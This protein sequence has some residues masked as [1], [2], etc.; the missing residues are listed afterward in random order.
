MLYR[1][2]R[3]TQFDPVTLE[4]QVAVGGVTLNNLSVE[5]VSESASLKAGDV[6]GL[7]VVGD[8]WAIHQRYVQP[9]TADATEAVTRAGRQTYYEHEFNYESTSS[10]TYTDLT[11]PGP[12]VH[13]VYVGASGIALVYVSANLGIF[14]DFC[15][16]EMGFEVGGST[17]I[18]A[19][20]FPPVLTFAVTPPSAMTATRLIRVRNLNPGMHTFKAKY[21][22]TVASSGLASAR[23]GDRELTVVAV[24]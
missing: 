8:T 15:Q 17:E 2:G 12:I 3:I 23:F 20:A 10:G 9:G 19:D 7:V 16:A 22:V 18:S 4:N 11:T 21:R 5:A 1:Q 6:V 13:S 14:G 24:L